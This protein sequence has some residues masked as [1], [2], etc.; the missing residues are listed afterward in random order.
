L[1]R[2]PAVARFVVEGAR[3]SPVEAA[4]FTLGDLV[5]LAASARP[6]EGAFSTAAAGAAAAAALL[7]A[8]PVEGDFR[9]VGSAAAVVVVAAA[10]LALRD[11]L[12]VL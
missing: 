12:I 6:F 4:F 1:M 2:A 9:S 10:L 3:L 5:K 7:L 8:R 11:M